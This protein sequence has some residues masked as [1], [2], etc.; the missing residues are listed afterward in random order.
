MLKTYQ[1]YLVQFSKTKITKIRKIQK[2][3][4]NVEE[5]YGNSFLDIL[6]YFLI[7]L[8]IAFSGIFM[9]L[10]LEYSTEW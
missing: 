7:H 1:A 2:K 8:W 6:E 10:T 3:K 9:S 5:N 4:K